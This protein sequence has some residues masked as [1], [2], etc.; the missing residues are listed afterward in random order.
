MTGL[1]AEPKC[2]GSLCNFSLRSQARPSSLEVVEIEETAMKAQ[3]LWECITGIS[4]Y[5]QVCLMVP[6]ESIS[7]FVDTYLF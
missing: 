5:T 6:R 2:T 3:N 7:M 4:I 1:G